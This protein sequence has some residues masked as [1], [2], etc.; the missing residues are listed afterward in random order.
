[1]V[2]RSMEYHIMVF[3]TLCKHFALPVIWR[4]C[5][6]DEFRTMDLKCK[7]LVGAS[8]LAKRWIIQHSSRLTHRFREQARSHMGFVLGSGYSVNGMLSTTSRSYPV[9][10]AYFS[11]GPRWRSLPTPRFCRICA[12]VPTSE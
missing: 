1:Q 9:N 12:P 4:I 7:T 2:V 11:G 8:L 5:F 3:Q 6:F 10:P